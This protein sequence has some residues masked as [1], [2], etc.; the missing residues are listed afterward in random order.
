MRIV[1]VLSR[2]YTGTPSCSQSGAGSVRYAVG[3]Q[4]PAHARTMI[5]TLAV[6][7][8]PCGSLAIRVIVRDPG[9]PKSTLGVQ[10]TVLGKNVSPVLLLDHRND[11]HGSVP[12]DALV[13]VARPSSETRTPAYTSIVADGR[14]I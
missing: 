14:T 13:S 3:T 10:P 12:V 7:V 2:Q 8:P 6:L 11:E 1:S 9:G 5:P 4:V